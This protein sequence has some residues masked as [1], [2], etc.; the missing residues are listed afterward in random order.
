MKVLITDDSK[1]AR[2]IKLIKT[3]NESITEGN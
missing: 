1:M 3:L 2:K